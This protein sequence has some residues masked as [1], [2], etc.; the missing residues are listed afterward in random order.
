M[1]TNFLIFVVVGPSGAGKGSIVSSLVA[2]VNDLWLSTSWTTRPRRQGEAPD[3]YVFVTPEEFA[4]AAASGCFLEWAEVFGHCYGTPV[5]DLSPGP[6]LL[7]EIDVQGASQVRASCPD[8]VVILV[9]PPSRQVQEQRLRLRGDDEGVIRR[10]LALA[11]AEEAMARG[12][13]DHEVVNDDLSRASDEVAG[14]VALHRSRRL[15]LPT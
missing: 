14:I 1:K 2:R 7:L 5:P 15:R 6:D 3:A 11:D 13:A 9:R 12:L 10:R 8:A 4:T